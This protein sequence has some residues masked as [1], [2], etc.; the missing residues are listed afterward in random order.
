QKSAAVETNQL[1]GICAVQC[2]AF[3]SLVAL[4]LTSSAC[5]GIESDNLFNDSTSQAVLYD[6]KL[7]ANKLTANKLTANS[8][9]GH[10]IASGRNGS[11]LTAG[12][13]EGLEATSDGRDLLEYM[14][15]CA[16]AGGDT[17]EFE[18][19]SVT[20]S[21][22]GLLGLATEWESSSLS[23]A[24]KEL[25]SACLL[26]HVNAYGTSVTVSGRVAGTLLADAT[27]RANYPV[28][29]GTFY[30][31]VFTSG[32]ST[33]YAC[34]GDDYDIAIAHS[35]VDRADRVCTD[36]DTGCGSI[37]VT[38]RCR[39]VCTTYT[40]HYG[41]TGC[42]GGGTTYDE[43]FSV[44]I[45]AE[46]PDSADQSCGAGGTCTTTPLATETA[47]AG[48][49][50]FLSCRDAT[51]CT[52]NCSEND[53]C[54]LDGAGAT[55]FTGN[56]SPLAT[57]E[58]DCYDT[59]TCSVTCNGTGAADSAWCEIDRKNSG[60]SSGFSTNAS[61]LNGA[62]CLLECGNTTGCTGFSTCH[63]SSYP[64][65]KSCGGGLYVCGRPCP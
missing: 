31:Q 23:A 63:D 49:R 56:V 37:V 17:L 1:Q 48:T 22:Q 30:G 61:C 46:D 59:V 12:N 33:L 47:T 10:A 5:V 18:Y 42:D 20:Y 64:T 32:S 4:L 2:K 16:L 34:Q 27:E 65:G 60:S 11:T 36:S 40:E 38:G 50:G 25:I 44:Y 45:E 15:R 8:L 41:W 35:P 13:L 3:V 54:T 29:E 58:V 24:K 43:T 53:T 26:G 14:T 57:A 28:Y 19:D 51:S 62:D 7:T 21:F 6:N 9:A 55:S 52:A 39:E